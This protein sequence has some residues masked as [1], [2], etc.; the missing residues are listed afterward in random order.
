MAGKKP[1]T[2]RGFLG[3]GF[4]FSAAA[5]LGGATG[6]GWGVREVQDPIAGGVSH[7]L[8]VGDWGDDRSGHVEQTNVASAMQKYT[9]K[10]GF[11]NDAL[12]MLGDNFYG[13]LAG[14]IGSAR[15][16]SQF[17]SMY[18]ASLCEGP[19]YAVP[20]NHDYQVDGSDKFAVQLAYAARGGTRWTMPSPWYSFLFPAVNPLLTIIGLDSNMPN[21]RAQPIPPDASYYTMTDAE[22]VSQL[23][24]LEAELQ[25]PL[26]TPFRIVMAHHPLYSN[27]GHGNNQTLIR[28]WDP[29]LRRY[30]VHLYVAG[31]DHDLQHIELPGHP[32]S[33]FLSGGGGAILA[34]VKSNSTGPYAAQT[35]GFSH[36]QV[37]EDLMICR[38]LGENGNLLHK[39]TK[40]P[41]GTVTVLT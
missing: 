4:A 21:E 22:R 23:Q 40:T 29:L 17:E 24:W 16:Q 15:W 10:W 11:R 41:D 1:L 25:K 12:L 14:G 9:A 27:G 38:H 13:N 35:H 36:I 32:T 3:N 31:H 34:P 20:G 37:R 39:F 5:V 19:A 28:D 30:G 18:P 6:C 8:M 33:F 26:R 7:L 2:R